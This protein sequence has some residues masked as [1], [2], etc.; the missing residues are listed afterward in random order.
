[1]FKTIH[2]DHLDWSLPAHRRGTLRGL[3]GRTCGVSRDGGRA[4]ALQPSRRP[5][6]SASASAYPHYLVSDQDARRCRIKQQRQPSHIREV[7][8]PTALSLRNPTAHSPKPPR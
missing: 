5:Q 1:M 2:T 4:R 7:S 3:H 6:A 8:V